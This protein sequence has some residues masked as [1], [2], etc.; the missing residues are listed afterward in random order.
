MKKQWAVY[1]ATKK[2]FKPA[3]FKLLI[4]IAMNTKRRKHNSN[5]VVTKEN[6]V[7]IA[8]CPDL[9]LICRAAT[10]Q[11]AIADLQEALALFF[12][13]MPGPADG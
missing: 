9:G 13:D 3:A 7:F 4:F 5:Y 11:E 10:E 2:Q 12:E 1:W 6:D 8:S